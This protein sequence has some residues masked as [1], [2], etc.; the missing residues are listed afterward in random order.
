[1]TIENS[2]VTLEQLIKAPINTVWEFFTN[3]EHITKWN[4]ASEDW[5][6]PYAQNDLRIGGKFSYRME[7]KKGQEGFDFSGSY[8]D[9]RINEFIAYTLDD[10]R[11][12]DIYFQDLGDETKIIQTFEIEHVYPREMQKEGWNSILLHFKEY[13]EAKG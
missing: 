6:C 9:I 7:E 11:K 12:V 5:H 8:V 4:H 2:T 10:D 3:P 13:A 1:M